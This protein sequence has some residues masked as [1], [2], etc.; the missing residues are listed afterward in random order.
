VIANLGAGQV[1]MAFDLRGPS[2]CNTSAC[3][4]GAHALGEAFEWIRHGRTHI[5]LAAGPGW[6]S[7]GLMSGSRTTWTITVGVMVFRKGVT[8]CPTV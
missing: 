8:M 2:Y 7:G 5:M 3:A 1:A 4:S 6:V